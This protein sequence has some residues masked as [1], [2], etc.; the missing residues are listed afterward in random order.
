VPELDWN[1]APADT[2]RSYPGFRL[3]ARSIND[4]AGLRD[5]FDK[6]GVN[7]HTRV[8]EIELV[9]RMDRNLTAVYWA[10]AVIGLVG[11]SLSLGASLWANVDRKRKQLSVLRLVGF[12]TRDIVWFPM[13]QALF[14]AVLGW[15]LAVSIYYVTAWVINSM[16]AGQ[17][18]AGQH[19]CRL[20]QDHYLIAL[21]L[22]CSAAVIAAALAG[23]RSARIEPSEGLREL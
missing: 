19:V 20:L 6:V 5:E 9:Q 11:F 13:V 8:A 18:E 2:E 12:R 1:G 4:V 3:Y 23:M 10:I 17:L 16:M 21:V 22:T 7:V 15:A 14:T